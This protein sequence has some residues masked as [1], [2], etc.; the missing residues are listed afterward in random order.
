M[1]DEFDEIIK[2]FLVE[3]EEMLDQIEPQLIEM[4][5]NIDKP[6]LNDEI[7]DAVFQVVSFL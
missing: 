7:I 1:S 3:G 6:K 4:S 5:K 2:E